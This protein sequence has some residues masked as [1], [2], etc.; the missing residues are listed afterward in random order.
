LPA[1]LPEPNEIQLEGGLGGR[2][3]PEVPGKLL[4]GV[5]EIR[6]FLKIKYKFIITIKFGMQ[7]NC[8]ELFS[9]AVLG[10]D[11]RGMSIFWVQVFEENDCRRLQLLTKICKQIS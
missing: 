4:E 6:A 1:V 8:S 5:Q 9:E 3:N 10:C 11:P 2:A 7:L